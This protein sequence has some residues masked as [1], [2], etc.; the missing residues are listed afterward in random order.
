M[1][2]AGV[3]FV[4]LFALIAVYTTHG[5]WTMGLSYLGFYLFIN[6]IPRIFGYTPIEASDS[7]WL[8]DNENHKM[9]IA[10]ACVI[11]RISRNDFIH[12]GATR[13]A[14]DQRFKQVPFKILGKPYWCPEPDFNPENHF[15]FHAN[16]VADKSE[17]R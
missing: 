17:L 7:F 15:K 4:V 13:F 2:D 5:F 1:I 8:I 11:P 12:L 9:N 16:S 3:T 6:Y 14:K 10:G